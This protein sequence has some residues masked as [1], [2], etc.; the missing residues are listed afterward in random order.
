MHLW[1]QPE[2]KSSDKLKSWNFA[3]SARNMGGRVDVS[4]W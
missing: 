4:P 3:R 2:A 1:H